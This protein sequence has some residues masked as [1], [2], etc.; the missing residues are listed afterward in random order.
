MNL[1][2]SDS[3][4]ILFVSGIGTDVGKSYATGWL[5]KKMA[6]AGKKVI[7][8]KF[9]Q[10]GNKDFSEDI[11]VHRKIMGIPLQTVDLTHLTAP[12]I[13]SYPAS[14]DLAARIDHK[15]LRIDMI[16]EATNTLNSQYDHVLIEGAG[17]LMV[18]LKNEYLTIDY[19]REHNL[20]VVLVTNGQLGSVSDTLLSLYALKNQE[21]PLFAL[22]YN[23]YFDKDK[24][25]AEDSRKYLRK[26]ME[27]NF[28]EALFIIMD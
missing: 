3:P 1:D 7:T 28:P 9:I 14:P 21:I 19:I 25:I 13:F 24:I 23:P 16:T 2:F 10:T 20:P 22:I 27:M 26:W 8:Q 5:A 11:E 15:E 17:G 4:S 12:V 6:E 18:P